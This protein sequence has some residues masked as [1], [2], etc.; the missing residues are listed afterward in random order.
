VKGSICFRVEAPEKETEDAILQQQSS[1]SRSDE[2]DFIMGQVFGALAQL[3]TTQSR[4]QLILDTE[5]AS[6]QVSPWLKR[7][8]WLQ[9][10][11]GISLDRAARYYGKE[12]VRIEYDVPTPPEQLMEG[13]VRVQPAFVGICGTGMRY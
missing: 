5:L 7:T 6:T 3:E 2:G 13:Q 1:V 11:K 4:E 10:L 12:D 8:R 9:Y